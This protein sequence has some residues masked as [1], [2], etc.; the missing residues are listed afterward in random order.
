[1]NE[2]PTIGEGDSEEA[3]CAKLV[4]ESILWNPIFFFWKGGVPPLK[5]YFY[6]AR[7]GER[8][9]FLEGWCDTHEK[10]IFSLLP[11]SPIVSQ[12]RF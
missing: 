10:M 5:I 1:M 2:V 11:P 9:R 7:R 8:K 6:I 4:R 3:F 12:M